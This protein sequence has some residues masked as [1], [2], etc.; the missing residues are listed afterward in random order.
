MKIP[1]MPQSFRCD[2]SLLHCCSKI[3]ESPSR[4][5]LYHTVAGSV[6]LSVTRSFLSPEVPLSFHS[7]VLSFSVLLPFFFSLAEFFPPSCFVCC[8]ALP[9]AYTL[10]SF[11]LRN[12][13]TFPLCLSLFCLPHHSFS[14]AHCLLYCCKQGSAI[15]LIFVFL[16][17]VWASNSVITSLPKFSLASPIMHFI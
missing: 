2:G 11:Q 3:S 10:L 15:R 9:S 16:L 12:P 14:F 7:Q 13:H 4:N 8:F 1:T 5:L 6:C 17:T